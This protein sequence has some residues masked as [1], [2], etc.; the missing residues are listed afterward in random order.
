MTARELTIEAGDF[1]CMALAWRRCDA[2]EELSRVLVV[3]SYS[4]FAVELFPAVIVVQ[5]KYKMYGQEK[6]SF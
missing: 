1:V 3:L 5:S 4:S 6:W 2:A